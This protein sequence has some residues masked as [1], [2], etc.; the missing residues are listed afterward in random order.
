MLRCKL[1]RGVYGS[2]IIYCYMSTRQIF[3]CFQ[4][5]RLIWMVPHGWYHPDRFYITTLL[6]THKIFSV[7]QITHVAI[8]KTYSLMKVRDIKNEKQIESSFFRDN[9]ST[10]KA[11]YHFSYLCKIN[12]SVKY[13]FVMK[14]RNEICLMDKTI[15][16]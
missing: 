1:L 12:T 15:L 7:K 14:K 6:W 2:Y 10:R 5:T 11:N 16:Q 8:A 4:M 13:L 3:I 9:V